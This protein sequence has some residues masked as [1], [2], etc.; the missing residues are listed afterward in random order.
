MTRAAFLD[1]DGVLNEVIVRDGKPLFARLCAP[2]SKRQALRQSA[3]GETSV[4]IQR[5]A[6]LA[7]TRADL[8]RIR[9]QDLG[10]RATKLGTRVCPDYALCFG[11]FFKT[12]QGS[13]IRNHPFAECERLRGLQAGAPARSNRQKATVGGHLE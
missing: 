11:K 4:P 9:S 2:F 8:D 10:H 13:R 3:I 12:P 1:R 6:F 5:L 7:R